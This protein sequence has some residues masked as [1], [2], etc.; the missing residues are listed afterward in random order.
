MT[1]YNYND[2][3]DNDDDDRD[4]SDKWDDGGGDV[5]H[6]ASAVDASRKEPSDRFAFIVAVE[7][8]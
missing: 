8:S 1:A 6:D 5:D 2:D 7:C 3:D 4:D